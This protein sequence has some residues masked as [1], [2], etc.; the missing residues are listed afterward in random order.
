MKPYEI[1]IF[2]CLICGSEEEHQTGAK[3]NGIKKTKCDNCHRKSKASSATRRNQM[4][5]KAEN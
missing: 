4:K 5:S 3:G 1:Y 2:T